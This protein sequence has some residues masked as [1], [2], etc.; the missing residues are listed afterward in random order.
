MHEVTPQPDLHRRAMT[1][2][3]NYAIELKGHVGSRSLRPLIDDFSVDQSKSGV[4]HLV[5]SIKDPSHLHGV[6]AYLASMN[7]EIISIAPIRPA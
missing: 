1:E 4:T 2:P 3:I 6:V 5:G 7:V